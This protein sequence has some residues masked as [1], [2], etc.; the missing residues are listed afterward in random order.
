MGITRVA[1]PEGLRSAIEAAREHDPKVV[2][3]AGIIG[4][5]IEVRR[6]QGRG[7]EPP[8]PACPARLRS[9]GEHE[10]YD[11]EAKYIDGPLPR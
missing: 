7:T 1:D 9:P 4:R 2:V 10:F 3:E 6:A 8:A 11:F 5:E